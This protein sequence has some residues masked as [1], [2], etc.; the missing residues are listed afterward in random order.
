M[1]P[2]AK[3]QAI[4]I[5]HDVHGLSIQRACQA[6]RL[7][8]TAHY[9]PP[10]DG[11]RLFR[12]QPVIDA[13]QAL[14]A[15]NTRWGFW[16]CYDRLRFDGQVW[17]HKRVHRVYCALR[18]NLPRRTR[19]RVPRRI[20][21]PLVAAPTLNTTWAIDFML[22]TLYDGRRFRTFNV[23][24]ESNRE[25]L[26]IEVGTTVPALRVIAVLEELIALHGAPRS[27]RCDNG[28]ELTSLALT[29]WCETRRIALRYIQ[30]GKPS[31]NAFIERFNRTYRTEIL[32][33]Y[34]FASVT[35]VRELTTDW[36]DRYNTQRPHDSLGHV[37]PLTYRPRST[38]LPASTSK[39]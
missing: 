32:D 36:L 8:R 18:L 11:V 29:A 34:V 3:R 25:G 9:Q 39:L 10:G 16:K 4:A 21:T 6:V 2:S 33:A 23:I 12:D 20:H 13:L 5:L 22:D 15:E 27:I 24:D 28:P 38:A 37:P 19:R 7:S 31:Q 26:A 17:N 30:P 35:E 14:V 1:T